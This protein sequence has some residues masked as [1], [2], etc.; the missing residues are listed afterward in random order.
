VT[1][2]KLLVAARHLW[3]GSSWWLQSYDEGCRSVWTLCHTR[4]QPRS[5]K[6]PDLNSCEVFLQTVWGYQMRLTK[7]TL[8]SNGRTM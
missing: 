3:N 8:L 6:I 1:Y 5:W 2:F 7:W 4:R